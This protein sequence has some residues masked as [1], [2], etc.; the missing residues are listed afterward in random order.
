M[1]SSSQLLRCVTFSDWTHGP[2]S[3]QPDTLTCPVNSCDLQLKKCENLP[4]KKQLLATI[5]RLAKQPATKLATSI[6]QVPTKLARAIS[7]VADLD[8][9]KTKLVSSMVKTDMA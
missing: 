3:L 7:L 5:A 9:D 1:A 8:E 2:F 4:T 6:K